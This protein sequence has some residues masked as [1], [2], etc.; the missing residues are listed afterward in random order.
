MGDLD[1]IA[2]ASW[3]LAQIDIAR[4]DYESAIPRVIEAFQI[5]RQL[6]RPDGIGAVGVT[7]GELLVAGGLTDDARQVLG[8]ARQAA[9]KVGD[10]EL[11]GRV[12]RLLGRL[13]DGPGREDWRHGRPC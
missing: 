2:A 8:E 12:D 10:A 4:E 7:L 9:D 11:V 13:N 6:Q 1:G 5:L 3:G